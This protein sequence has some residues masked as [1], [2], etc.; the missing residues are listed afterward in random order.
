MKWLVTCLVI[1]CG[2]SGCRG[3]QTSF[4]TLAPFGSSRV[5]PPSTN[6]FNASSPYYNRNAAPQTATPTGPGSMPAASQSGGETSGQ[7]MSNTSASNSAATWVS[8]LRQAVAEGIRPALDASTQ[9]SGIQA[10]SYQDIASSGSSLRLKGMRVND[11]TNSGAISEPARFVP[12]GATVEIAQ[13]PPAPAGS[14][15]APASTT[16]VASAQASDQ[17]VPVSAASQSTLNWK[18]RP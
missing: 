1:V 3:S 15:T 5:P 2:L 7:V 18:S 9:S 12:A 4:N 13:L 6:H 14:T 10:V 11:A 8:P 16:V 17:A